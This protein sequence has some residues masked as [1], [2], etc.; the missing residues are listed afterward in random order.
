MEELGD[1]EGEVMKAESSLRERQGRVLGTCRRGGT[2][3]H[4]VQVGGKGVNT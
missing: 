4:G 2:L 3:R 1:G